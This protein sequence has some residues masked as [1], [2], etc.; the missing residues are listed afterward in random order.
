MSH[1]TTCIFYMEAICL[2]LYVQHHPSLLK[3]SR[4]IVP[5][6]TFSFSPKIPF[7]FLSNFSSSHILTW[8][9]FP[10]SWWQEQDY[11]KMIFFLYISIFIFKYMPVVC[12]H[13]PLASHNYIQKEF[14]LLMST[15]SKVPT[16]YKPLLRSCYRTFSAI[17]NGYSMCIIIISIIWSLCQV[18]NPL[19]GNICI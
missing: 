16:T 19:L 7:L 11:W 6:D 10:F 2:L 14:L 15:R 18:V 4:K 17:E 9:H 8:K 12:L 3:E 5:K 1:V 13:L